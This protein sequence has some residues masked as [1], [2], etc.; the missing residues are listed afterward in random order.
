MMSIKTISD[1]M[2]IVLSVYAMVA[3]TLPVPMMVILFMLNIPF[4]G[5]YV[6]PNRIVT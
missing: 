5:S 2:P 6:F 1:A 4:V 3:P